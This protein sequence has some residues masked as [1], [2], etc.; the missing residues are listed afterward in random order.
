MQPFVR[1]Q[2]YRIE[3]LIEIVRL[4]RAPDGCPWDR[5]QDHRSLRSGFIEET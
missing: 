3:D 4:L 5:E 1:K 2:N